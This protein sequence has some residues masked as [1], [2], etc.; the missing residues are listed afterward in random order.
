[1]KIRK[2]TRTVLS[3]LRTLG[4]S[5]PKGDW[6]QHIR[7]IN[8][9]GPIV[10]VDS[11]QLTKGATKVSNKGAKLRGNQTN[12]LSQDWIEAVATEKFKPKTTDPAILAVRKA[13]D[14]QQPIKTLIIGVDKVDKKIKLIPVEVPNKAKIRR[15]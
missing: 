6:E 9:D 14:K 11:K 5:A 3:A 4:F 7:G 12:Q 15:H 2:S 1:M 13:I 10:I 8:K